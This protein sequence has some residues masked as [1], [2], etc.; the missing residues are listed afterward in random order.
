VGELFAAA[1]KVIAV[2]CLDGILNGR[3]HRV[4]GTEDGALDKLDLTGHASLE[5]AS[6]SSARLLSLPPCLGRAGLAPLVWRGCPLRGA[7]VA[8]WVVATSGRVDG[9]IVCLARVL[10]GPVGRV[11]LGQAVGRVWAD[12]W[13][14]V[15]GV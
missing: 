5:A 14:A 4:V 1:L 3:R 9:T 12:F 8:G 15:E 2:L 6:G 10:G 13:V 11:R 7:K